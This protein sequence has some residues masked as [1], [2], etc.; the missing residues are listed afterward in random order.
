M[1]C[2]RI[3][4]CEWISLDIRIFLLFVVFGF[5]IKRY[6]NADRVL[7]C[8]IVF[9]ILLKSIRKSNL[10]LTVTF[11][12]G[13]FYLCGTIHNR[14]SV[15]NLSSMVVFCFF[16]LPFLDMAVYSVWPF[17]FL[18]LWKICKFRLKFCIENSYHIIL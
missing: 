3:M 9:L 1:C 15:F 10:Y 17:D 2:Y 13:T 14:W 7:L 18:S 5:S 6:R 11:R 4:W 12:N 8:A 16:Q